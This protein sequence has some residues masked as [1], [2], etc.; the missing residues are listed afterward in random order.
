MNPGLAVAFAGTPDFALPAIDAVAASR[1]RLVVVYTQP[2]RPAGRGRKL[3]ASPVR[4][5][6]RALGLPVEQP[7]SLRDPD[8][9]SGLARY[10]PD[11]MLVVAYGLLLP[12]PVLD[13]P[14]LG[15]LNIHGSLLPRWRGAAPVARAIEA[16]DART[17]VCIMRM[18]AGL[19]TG[20]VL[21]C[22]ETAIGPRENAGELQARL[23]VTGAALA[24][25]A[26]DAIA[27]GS[28]VATAQDETQATYARK[29]EKSE[30]R[31]DWRESA[32]V[33]ERRV[34]AFNPWPVAEAVFDGG[35]IRI[36]DA[37]AVAT[38]SGAAPGAILS[39]DSSGIVVK[40]GD[41]ALVLLRVQL[42]GRRVISAAEFASAWPLAGMV[43]A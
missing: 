32:L 23:A 33:L 18:E 26:L 6:A 36:F 21:R 9:Q 15:C 37:Q 40:T 31:L 12:Q 8:A 28:I 1:H 14:R 7:Q 35:Q 2:D 24:M 20:P 30:A 3:A 19:D 43:L 42:P 38:D 39:A 11:V 25:E 17:G 4:Q 34:R 41:Q 13:T 5:R 16:G 29:L 22:T 10:A 27:A